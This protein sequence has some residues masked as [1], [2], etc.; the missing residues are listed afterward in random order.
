VSNSATTNYNAASGV[1]DGF[2]IDL[3]GSG[4]RVN[5][6]LIG[7]SGAAG[8]TYQRGMVGDIFTEM[9]AAYFHVAAGTGQFWVLDYEW[10]N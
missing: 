9:Q 2:Y 6:T 4:S 10:T 5:G 3:S 8:E 7:Y 1:P